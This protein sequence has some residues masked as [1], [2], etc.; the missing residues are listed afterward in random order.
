MTFTFTP[1][2]RRYAQ[3]AAAADRSAWSVE[4]DIGWTRIDAALAWQTPDLLAALR[5]AAIIES[6]HPVNLQRLLRFTWD[7]V[8][9]GVVF[10][11]EMYEGFKHFHAL[12]TYLEIVGHTPAIT[13]DDIVGAR[14]SAMTESPGSEPS[15]IERLVEFMLSEHLASF[16]FRR[17]AERAREPVLAAL[18]SLIAADE[19]RHAQSASDLIAKRIAED[20]SLVPAVLDAA[21]GFHHFGEEAVG[22][23]PVAMPGDPMAIRT[24]ARRIERLCG[25]RLVDHLKHTLDQPRTGSAP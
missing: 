20:P 18:L 10:S 12:R 22:E 11:L 14:R 7:D 6:F 2:A 9:A 17:L 23:V 8:D 13:D 5:D 21:A 3:H 25:V 16:F 19:V 24:F 4:R 1:V 15:L